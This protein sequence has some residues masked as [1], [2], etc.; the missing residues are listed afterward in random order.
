MTD[1]SAIGPEELTDVSKTR[2][3]VY[4]SVADSET[5][6]RQGMTERSVRRP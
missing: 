6:P 3:N 1:I 4:L 5:N 2:T